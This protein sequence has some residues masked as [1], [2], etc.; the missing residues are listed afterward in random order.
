MEAL[1]ARIEAVTG[2]LLAATDAEAWDRCRELLSERGELLERL[3]AALPDGRRL[4]RPV[5]DRLARLREQ[6]EILVTR[7]AAARDQVSRELQ[8]LSRRQQGGTRETAG[9]LIN[10]RA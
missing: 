1:L 6:E 9:R 2:Q 3:A 8:R 5:A 7:L 10:H 4:P